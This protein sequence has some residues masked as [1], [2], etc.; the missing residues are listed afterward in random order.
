MLPNFPCRRRL[1]RVAKFGTAVPHLARL[2]TRAGMPSGQFG[3]SIQITKGGLER[4]S[5]ASLDHTATDVPAS[6]CCF[7]LFG[8]PHLAIRSSC[9]R[10][11]LTSTERRRRGPGRCHDGIIHQSMNFQ[12]EMGERVLSITVASALF[13]RFADE[14]CYVRLDK[15]I[16]AE[17]PFT[18]PK[19]KLSLQEAASLKPIP[20]NS[21]RGSQVLPPS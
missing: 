8:V 21:T 1:K 14:D 18:R 7:E 10:H 17:Q 16:G 5:V 20:A 11:L 12:K 15:T 9:R 3:R 4:V 6:A 2:R 19:P 13:I